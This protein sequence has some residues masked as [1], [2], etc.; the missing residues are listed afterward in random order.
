MDYLK[1]NHNENLQSYIYEF[2]NSQNFIF[3]RELY[4]I[5]F[6]LIVLLIKKYGYALAL[7]DIS[8]LDFNR[9]KDIDDN[10][11]FLKKINRAIYKRELKLE[12]LK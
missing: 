5:N 2:N 1:N 10:Y 9:K 4:K 7:E 3:I 11:V 8:E 12:D 6:D